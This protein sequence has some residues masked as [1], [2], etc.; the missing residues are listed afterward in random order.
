M[1][2]DKNKLSSIINNARTLC[3]PEGD[4]KI[5]MVK[6]SNKSTLDAEPIYESNDMG[7]SY[8]KAVNSK[9]PEFI[10][11]SMLNERIEMPG[12]S[13]SILD[14]LNVPAYTKPMTNVNVLKENTTQVNSNVDYSIIKAIVNECLREYFNNKQ[15]INEST[16]LQTI[17]LQNGNISLVDNKGNVYKAKLVKIGNTNEK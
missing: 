9:M 5:N 1:A 10:K 17:G 3:S 13:V 6:T 2:I 4:R 15:S 11:N 16:T 8:D 12:S 14:E 7:I